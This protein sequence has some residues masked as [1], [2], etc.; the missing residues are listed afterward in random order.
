[1]IGQ[2]AE[3][4]GFWAEVPALPGCVSQ[5]EMRDELMANLR[6]AIAGWLAVAPP[7][8]RERMERGRGVNQVTG[9]DF[10]RLIQRKDW[11]LARTRCLLGLFP[12]RKQRFGCGGG[13][14]HVRPP[15]RRRGRGGGWK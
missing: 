4:G 10:A 6:E 14:G 5:G 9:R 11:T 2:R 8:P 3:E 13:G 7:R 15:P 1:M 12:R